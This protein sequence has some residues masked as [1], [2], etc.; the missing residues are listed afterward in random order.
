MD[1]YRFRLPGFDNAYTRRSRSLAYLVIVQAKI[2][3]L[4]L[5]EEKAAETC[6]LARAAHLKVMGMI[7]IFLPHPDA[8]TFLRSG[9]L[10]EIHK[11]VVATGADI[12][13]FGT[14]LTP[15][16]AGNIEAF[17]KIPVVDRTGL[18]LEIFGRRA[19]S[20]EGKLQVELAQLRY[21]LPRLGGLGTVM[22][23]LG[24]GIGTRGPGEQELERDRRKVRRRIDQVKDK[25]EDVR[26]HRELLRS[27]RNKKNFVSAALVGYT[28]A[29]KS[30]LMNAL[31]GANVKVED[32]VF[33]TLDPK[34]RVAT[35]NGNQQYLF[36][37]T[38]GFM[39]DLPHTLIESFRATLEE[40]V[41]ADLL[42]HVLDISQQ[43]ARD[44]KAAVEKVL[45]E[46]GVKDKPVI[47]ALNKADLLDENEKKRGEQAFPEG[48]LISAREK[49]GMEHLL[50]RLEE[51][52]QHEVKN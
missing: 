10:E 47:L 22:S 38:V 1:F 5:L 6:E 15:S 31:T 32:Q 24:G 35:M 23:R 40:V 43:H 50:A 34:T 33:A 8:G 2:K 36:I 41:E 13:V 21:V 25:L 12:L 20:S 17:M 27:G 37:D 11:D 48:V 52:R 28:N 42:I 19:Q 30:S 44:L 29:G 16:Q 9:K 7:K 26:K 49:H 18:I 46:I 14:D 45:E 39:R 3:S 51:V 4:P